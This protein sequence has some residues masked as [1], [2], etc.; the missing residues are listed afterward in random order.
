MQLFGHPL[1][2]GS[3]P[4]PSWT[5]CSEYH[6]CLR[7]AEIR[8]EKQTQTHAEHVDKMITISSDECRWAREQ[9]TLYILYMV[10]M[11]ILDRFSPSKHAYSVC[12]TSG[13]PLIIRRP[14]SQKAHKSEGPLV[15]RPTS[16]NF[17]HMNLL[18]DGPTSW[19]WVRG[20]AEK[21]WGCGSEGQNWGT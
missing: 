19:G 9:N 16:Q 3:L 17:W 4:L 8:Q 5:Q 21:W 7:I 13:S 6:K 14:S 2:M 18:A 1:Y 15:R 12:V 20:G 11:L 10:E